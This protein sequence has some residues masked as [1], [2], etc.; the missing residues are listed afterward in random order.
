MPKFFTPFSKSHHYSFLPLDPSS[1]CIS[2]L[3]VPKHT[4]QGPGRSLQPPAP[5]LPGWTPTP[6]PHIRPGAQPE[7]L[8]RSI[9]FSNV[10]QRF[11][12]LPSSP[13]PPAGSPLDR[14]CPLSS[15]PP[16]RPPSNLFLLLTGSQTVDLWFDI[17]SGEVDFLLGTS[18]GPRCQAAWQAKGQAPAG[19]STLPATPHSQNLHATPSALPLGDSAWPSP[20][21]PEAL[22]S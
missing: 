8:S 3:N 5:I 16:Q 2:G 1:H 21:P 10:T 19:M 20:P 17:E 14:E 6:L 12:T 15:A 11:S 18:V 9:Q 7:A 22:V 13:A 4:H